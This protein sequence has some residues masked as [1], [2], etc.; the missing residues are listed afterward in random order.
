M[1]KLEVIL[2][3]LNVAF[4]LFVVCCIPF[5]VQIWRTAKAMGETL[6]VLNESL[7]LIMVNLAELTTNVN[8][9][10]ATVQREVEDLSLTME[11][12]RG[13]MGLLAGLEEVVRQRLRMPFA[14][15]MRTVSALLRGGEVF[16]RLLLTDPRQKR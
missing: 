5:L 14:G 13:V 10:T 16:L 9:T 11:R 7:P 6:K 4:L 8:R 15:T 3:V 12:I 1:E 2:I